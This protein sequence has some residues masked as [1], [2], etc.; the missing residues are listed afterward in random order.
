[1]VDE[2]TSTVFDLFLADENPVWVANRLLQFFGQDPEP[3]EDVDLSWLTD[4]ATLQ[5][6]FL[7]T[8]NN[9]ALAAEAGVNDTLF[10]DIWKRN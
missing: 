8:L 4:R 6:G 7:G 10:E 5:V 9:A 2:L 1:M 3:L